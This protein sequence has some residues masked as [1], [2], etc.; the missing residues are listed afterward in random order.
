MIVGNA[1]GYD[2]GSCSTGVI[3]DNAFV[4]PQG[5]ETMFVAAPAVGGNSGGPIVDVSGN[6]IGS[7]TFGFANEETLG[8]GVAQFMMEPIV[9]KLIVQGETLVADFPQ[10]VSA[11]EA[12]THSTYENRKATF[13]GTAYRIQTSDV[14]LYF[15]GMLGVNPSVPRQGMMFSDVAS[16]SPIQS[17]DVVYEITYTPNDATFDPNYNGGNPVTIPIGEHQRSVANAT[18]FIDETN[19]SSVI[20][21]IVRN[22]ATTT[23]SGLS[24]GSDIDYMPESTDKYLQNVLLEKRSC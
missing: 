23:V 6:V 17:N 12:N 20:V 9:K 16:P 24:W 14:F 2:V 1:R 15:P 13:N 3:R 11:V 7:L 5:V 19:V 21:R 18:W 22:N 4:F 10:Y 8:G